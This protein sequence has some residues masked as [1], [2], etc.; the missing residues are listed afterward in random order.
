MTEPARLP[1]ARGLSAEEPRPMDAVLAGYPWLPRMIDKARAA[2]AGTL[3]H[4]FRYPCPIDAVCLRR[5][6]IDASTFMHIAQAAPSDD[7]VLEGLAAAGA[8]PSFTAAFDPVRLNA[9]LH[10]PGS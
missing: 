8:R 2:K 6:N 1:V 4:Y 9:R 3:G 7:A 10:K 5:L